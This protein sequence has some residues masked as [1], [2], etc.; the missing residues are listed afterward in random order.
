MQYYVYNRPENKVHHENPV[1]FTWYP[2]SE[3]AE[4]QIYVYD[5]KGELA[6]SFSDITINF[7]TPVCVMNPGKYTY[8][9]TTGSKEIIKNQPFEIAEDAAQTPLLPRDA[10]YAAIGQHPRI[11]LNNDDINRLK[12]DKEKSLK[13]VWES[14]M[15][16]AVSD[17][18]EKTVHSEPNF[19]PGN[20]RV[21]SL[22]R[23]MYIDCQ[24]ALYA[25]KHCAIAWR[26]T[27]DRIYLDAAKRWLLSIAG[28]NTEGAT[29]RTYNDESAFRLTTALAWG[30]DWLYD[31]LTD[32]E[33][34]VVKD[35]LIIRGRELFDYVKHQIQIHIKL[36]D[37]HGVRSLS[38]SLVPAALALYGE[39]DEA[40]DWL[41][42]TIEYFYTI[43]TPWGGEDGGW[44][45][46]PAYWQ[47]GISFFTEAIC[48]IQKATDIQI[49]KR[50]FFQN[51][52]DFPLYTYSQD[53]R[54]MAFGDMSDLG[55]Y[56]GLKAG[57][58]LRILSAL[59]E[60]ENRHQYAWYFEQAKVR[61]V[62]TENKFYNYG[63]WNFSFDELF[64]RMIFNPIEPEA[65]AD[66]VSLKWFHDN[67]WVSLH[68]DMAKEED[69]IAFMF[70]ASPYGAVSHSHGDQNAFVLHAFGEPL[71]IQ[72]GYYVGFWSE[73]HINWRRHTKSKN[74]ILVDDIGQYADMK[75]T[76]QAEE[77]NGSAKSQFE[78]LMASNGS[79]EACEKVE[80][81]YYI[82]GDATNAFAM[83]VP[84][85]KSNKRHILFIEDSV[86]VMIDEI[87]LEQEA[88]VSWLLHGLEPFI[89]GENQC[90]L[91]HNHVTMEVLLA[92]AEM[93]LSQTNVFENV[94]EEELKGLD[95][96][97]HMKATTREVARS[98]RIVS[99]LYPYKKGDKKTVTLKIEA[100]IE[101]SIDGKKHEIIKKNED[102]RL[103]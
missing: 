18:A 73:M 45:E 54:F 35:A 85:L 5:Q 33:R 92:G 98:H 6:Y 22:W 91:Q 55:D 61:G 19:Y 9:V 30:Y 34:Q 15:A 50:P 88:N 97:W 60:S 100:S 38:M 69:H 74:A 59:S 39:V 67:G 49:S 28:W 25:I 12:V 79:I 53:L 58:T 29:A 26:V 36:L 40:K 43:F 32:D 21:I 24:E 102:Y 2:I 17:W 80:D 57:Y 82:R 101:V 11:W 48:L 86:F 96:Q 37:S 44:A 13:T 83:S 10:R 41:D 72:S 8:S 20:K 62:G 71:A 56:P 94:Q 16:D 47:S 1:R 63:W 81:Y 7:Y 99:V 95:E 27:N 84:Y 14:F 89:L 75:K 42:Y 70:K 52:A 76:N 103:D 46:G 78:N 77:M 4:Y 31:D 3:E 68:K 23:Q 66:G 90:T 87:E 51:T 93:D 65:P 64:F